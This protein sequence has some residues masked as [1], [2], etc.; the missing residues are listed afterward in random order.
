MAVLPLTPAVPDLVPA[1]G[2]PESPK[3]VASAVMKQKIQR[4]DLLRTDSGSVTLG[5]ALLGGVVDGGLSSWRG[6]VEVDDAVLTDGEQIVL[7]GAVRNVGSS[8]VDGL[9][10][11]VDADPGDGRVEVAIAVPVMKRRLLR[12]A[13]VSY[14]VRR[15]QGRAV[16][17]LPRGEDVR[18]VDDGVNATLGRKRSWWVEAG[19]WGLYVM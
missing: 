15:A 9:P 3:D 5:G 2:L 17:V 14:E 12:E 18:Y 6:R 19:A 1:L 16:S 4:Y 10:L 13:T 7:A 11:V 8:D